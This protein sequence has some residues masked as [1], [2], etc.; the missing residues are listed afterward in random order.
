[1]CQ[2]PN[3]GDEEKETAAVLIYQKKN[4]ASLILSDSTKMHSSAWFWFSC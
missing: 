4:A 3:L 1:M 2:L